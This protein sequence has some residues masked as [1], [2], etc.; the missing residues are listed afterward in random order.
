M[1]AP[2]F[3]VAA[4]RRTIRQLQQERFF[5]RDCRDLFRGQARS[6][7]IEAVEH[8]SEVGMIRSGNEPPGG[9][10]RADVRA[11][12]LRFIANPDAVPHGVLR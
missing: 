8:E 4:H 11:P 12:G 9:T 10:G 5:A 6:K 7:G 2:G 3:Q 1:L